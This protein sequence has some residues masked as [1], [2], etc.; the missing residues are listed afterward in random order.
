V[1]TDPFVDYYELLQVS[2]NADDDTIQ[3]VFRHLA[4]KYHPDAATGGDVQR[5]N[6]LLDACRV[7]TDATQ[8]AAYDIAYKRHWEQ[9]WGVAAQASG[10]DVVGEDAAC[11][12]RLLT[13]LY[14][15]RRRDMRKPGMGEVELA[16]LMDL[17]I[18]HLT[19]HVWYLREKGWIER[20]DTGH[21]AITANGVDRVERR[22]VSVGPERWIEARPDV[23]PDSG[24]AAPAKTA[25]K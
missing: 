23:E 14:V 22:H 12:E 13:L 10:D 19:F 11:R 24:A 18:E 9:T 7:L 16:R 21:L 5:F 2:P 15:Q 6:R 17:P 20:T 8:R 25:P 1:T 4:K 3:R